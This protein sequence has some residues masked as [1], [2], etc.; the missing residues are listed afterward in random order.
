MANRKLQ[1]K[2][3]SAVVIRMHNIF[4]GYVLAWE[5]SFPLLPSCQPFLYFC[6]M[7]GYELWLKIK[8]SNSK[9][10]DE[11][12]GKGSEHQFPN[13]LVRSL[14]DGVSRKRIDFTIRT[15]GEFDII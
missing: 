4:G 2:T 8:D 10:A 13:L 9:M 12:T 5:F 3:E 11:N 1:S 6:S 15:Y 14:Q 7:Y